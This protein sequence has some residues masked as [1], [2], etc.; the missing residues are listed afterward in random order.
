MYNKGDFCRY[1][2][3]FKVEKG[4]EH[5]HT[6][7]VK[8]SGAFYISSEEEDT[9][10][11]NYIL[12]MENEE[13]LY[14]TEKHKSI[15][16]IVIDLDFRFHKEKSVVRKYDDETI[17][18]IIKVYV[19][20]ISEFYD[21]EKIVFYVME[22]PH[23]V[24]DKGLIKDGIH[25]IIP[26]VV[27]K[28]SVQYLLRK[29]VLQA[30]APIISGI[31]AINDISDV[32]DEAVI[33]RNNWQMYGSK[34]P[35][36]DAYKVT[37]VI[38]YLN[39]ESIKDITDPKANNTAYVELLSIR[40]KYNESKLKIEKASDIQLFE[41]QKKLEEKHK[42]DKR[43]SKKLNT[44][45]NTCDSLEFIGRLVDI[46]SVDRANSYEEWIRV[47]WCLRNIDFRLVDTWVEFSKKSSKYVE[48]ECERLWNHM[49][50]DGLG[51]GTLHMWCKQDNPESY[52][53]LMEKDL[54][55]LLYRSRTETHHDIAKV[56]H[57][58]YKY[59]Y[60]CVSIKHNYWYEFRNH[61]WVPCDSGHWLRA[62]ISTDV[63]RE[64]CAAAAYYNNKAS[65]EEMEADQQRYL[66]DAKKLNGI[67]LKLKQGPFKD[68]VMKECK[69]L[70]YTEKFEEKLDSRCHLLG[71][72]NG[73]YDLETEEF[74]EGRPE[75]YISFSTGINFI[76]YDPVHPSMSEV[77]DFLEKV[78][79]KQDIRDYVMTVLSS[80]LNGN[81]REERF[82]I[83]T[84]VG[85]HAK[86]TLIM[87]ADGNLKMVQDIVVGDQLM[88]DDSKPRNV[89]QLYRGRDDM[90]KII[91]VKGDPFVVNM[92][93]I[94][95]LKVKNGTIIDISC[96]DLLTT[97]A[98][99]LLPYLYLYKTAVE[100]PEQPTDTDPYFVGLNLDGESIPDNYKKNSREKR[101]LLLAG[102]LDRNALYDKNTFKNYLP[103]PTDA[104][105]TDVMHLARSLGLSCFETSTKGILEIYGSYG[106]DDL[107]EFKYELLPQDDFYGFELDGNHRYLMDDF[108]VTHNSNGKS[109]IIELFE[110]SFG[111]Y[112]C[113]FP[114]TL[115]TQKRAA[116]NAANSEVARSKGKRFACLQEPSE[117]E[118]LNI[119]FMKELTGGDKIMARALFKEPIEFKPQFKMIL[120]C[121]HL[122]NVPSDDGGTWRR[123]R[124]VEFTS[125]FTDNPDSNKPHEFLADTE[126][127][128]RFDDWK[129]HFMALLITYYKKYKA[130][131]IYEPEDVLK[132]TKEY[133]KNN[134]CFLEYIDQE[135]EAD[136]RGFLSVNDA[137]SKFN[138][139]IKDNAT[140]I[141]GVSKKAFTSSIEARLGKIVNCHKVNG[142]KA[143]RFRQ[144][145]IEEDD[146]L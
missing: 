22:K 10:L 55:N 73:V 68:N 113:K 39:A 36:C 45:K 104:H 42:M 38:E 102:I 2:M 70:F 5:T 128:S 110:S 65:L 99:N 127:S 31:G 3:K 35:N 94:L 92:N 107:I 103:T 14:L 93:H 131:G 15:G 1:L 26:D 63:V 61:R 41:K 108:T 21:F 44:K 82:H 62:R 90:I 53:K 96:R 95:S 100:Y 86:D 20:A 37:R 139:W 111:E 66:E 67:A 105:K 80:F 4:C 78:F 137:Y 112:C 124:V 129:E 81:I 140:H 134:D 50:D 7:I 118:K 97:S 83:W 119:G 84:G 142:W 88:G 52:K 123:I 34:K 130:S 74:R 30:L 49:R 25:I 133:Q 135:I 32:V 126:L 48:G 77:H 6:S 12:A 121:N 143:F 141:K 54:A 57:F 64:Y 71:F 33:H 116:S 144:D 27:T 106:V 72:D 122:P 87:M 89:L 11:E 115:L 138:S 51:V 76:E 59:D 75:D 91:P 98:S 120:T 136:E 69:E 43:L 114:I 40:N 17:I 19:A 24:V 47:G 18:S 28:P 23:P 79:T 60:V 9:F 145:M 125:K 146:G 46:L 8:P 132:C 58:M 16:P 85:C 109:K 13:E 117:D 56:V 29:R 101:L